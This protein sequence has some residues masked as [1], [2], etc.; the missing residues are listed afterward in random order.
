M[1]ACVS[2]SNNPE[3]NTLFKV[4]N[5]EI[6]SYRMPFDLVVL[7]LMQTESTGNILYKKQIEGD[8]I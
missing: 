4:V 1:W 8:N 5:T 6:K 7:E 3:N 2:P